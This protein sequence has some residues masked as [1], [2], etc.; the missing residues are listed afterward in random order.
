[1]GTERGASP[2]RSPL[3]RFSNP[4]FQE[5]P[6]LLEDFLRTFTEVVR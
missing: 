1:M 6:A 3:L 2:S 4:L 5:E